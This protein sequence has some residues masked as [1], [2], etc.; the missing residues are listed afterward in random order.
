M[1]GVSCAFHLAE[2]GVDVVLLE[3]GQLG[4][5]STTKAAGGVRAQFSDPVNVLLG[6]RGLEAFARFGERPGFEIDFR[7]DGYLFLLTRP[8][9]VAHFE[10]SVVLQNELGVPSRMI[11][12]AE[13]GRLSPLISTEGLLAAAFSPEDGLANPDAVVQ[14][15]AHGARRHGADLITGCA[16]IGIEQSGGEIAVVRTTAGDVGTGTVVCA[17]GAWSSAIGEMVGVDLPVTPYRRQIAC[18]ETLD[19]LPAC[20]PMTI[21]FESTFYFH[22][23]GGGVLTG[24]SDPAVGPGFSERFDPGWLLDLGVAIARR[25][26]SLQDAGIQSTWAGLYE[27]TPDHNGIVGEVSEPSRFIVATGFSGHGFLMGPAVGEVVRDLYLERTP[28]VE[29]SPLGP[30]RF[31]DAGGRFELNVV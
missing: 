18:T 31:E 27:V 15:Y 12:P 16:V 24:L 8:D 4:A 11:E 25:A 28:L 10:T 1:I 9:D 13:A 19:D 20:F 17:A 7:R 22:R 21:E 3:R 29:V 30:Q 2:A 26:P 23:E 5:G 6:A 14:G